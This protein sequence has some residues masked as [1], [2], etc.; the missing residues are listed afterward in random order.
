MGIN[1]GVRNYVT[2]GIWTYS[3]C[4]NIL[5]IAR[6]PNKLPGIR[7]KMPGFKTKGQDLEFRHYGDPELIASIWE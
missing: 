1:A 2:K 4:R 3:N 5:I 6:I 7:N